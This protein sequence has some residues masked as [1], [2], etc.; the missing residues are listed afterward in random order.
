MGETEKVVTLNAEQVAELDRQLSEMR[1]QVN[2][3]LTLITAATEI[4]GR[5]PDTA[6]RMMESIL[7]Q[8][9][10]INREIRRFSDAFEKSL[11]IHHEMKPY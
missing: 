4:M 3:Y 8:P 7:Q 5:K 9:V 1:H 11:G 2:N 10:K 6:A